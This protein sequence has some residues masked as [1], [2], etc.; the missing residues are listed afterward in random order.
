LPEQAHLPASPAPLP[1][2]AAD[3]VDRIV[4][5]SHEIGAA[6]AR[7]REKSAEARRARADRMPDPI[8]GFR[9]LNEQGGRERAVGLTLSFPIGAARRA[10]S[11]QVEGA[12]AS[13]ARADLTM[14]RRDVREGAELAVAA[15]GARIEVWQRQR[16]A[17]DA[18]ETSAAKYDRAYALGE[19]GLAEVL[20]ARRTAQ[21][22]ALAERRAL[23]DAIESVARVEV[24]AHELWHRV[25][26]GPADAHAHEGAAAPL[27]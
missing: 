16:E 2:A 22:A 5:R 23:V 12:N 15:A 17:R 3:W 6:E 26:D 4:A 21:D 10:A 9:V 14:V 27:P 7:V 18:A 19:S 20:A 8:V 13:G 1:G 24:D 25:D 11:A